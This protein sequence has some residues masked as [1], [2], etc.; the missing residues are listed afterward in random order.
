MKIS[1]EALMGD[2]EFGIDPKPVE[3]IANEI[4]KAEAEANKPSISGGFGGGGSGISAGTSAS[5]QKAKDQYEKLQE[6]VAKA[7]REIELA[8]I[9]H[10]TSSVEVQ[11]A[12]TKYQQ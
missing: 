10:G 4:K 3:A 8:A 12:F 2:Q 6:S 7:K 11:N 5:V 1:G 9:A